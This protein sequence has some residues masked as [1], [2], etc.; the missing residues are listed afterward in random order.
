MT[1]Q[2]DIPELVKVPAEKALRRQRKLAQY[3][4][5]N[6]RFDIF[7]TIHVIFLEKATIEN[8]EFEL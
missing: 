8:R 7:A 6:S 1:Q 5:L 3:I 4:S 2:K